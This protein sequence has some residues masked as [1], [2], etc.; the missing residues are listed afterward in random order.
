LLILSFLDLTLQSPPKKKILL[1]RGQSE[2][3]N[4]EPISNKGSDLFDNAHLKEKIASY[5][6]KEDPTLSSNS[7]SS[8][9]QDNSNSRHAGSLDKVVEDP[10]RNSLNR[11]RANLPPTFGEDQFN[12]AVMQQ[13]LESPPPSKDKFTNIDRMLADHK[14]K[15]AIE[16]FIDLKIPDQHASPYLKKQRTP[17]SGSKVSFDL[18]KGILHQHV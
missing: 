12:N 8:Q 2:S 18:N 3:L 15:K 14:K 10:K 5:D 11:D 4:E 16:K 13:V 7:R 9:R 1:Y 17:K 6:L